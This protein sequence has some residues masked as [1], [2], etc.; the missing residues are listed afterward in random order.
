MEEFKRSEGYTRVKERNP[1][2]WKDRH[3]PCL[4]SW[5]Q[6]FADH[7]PEE[8]APS[9]SMIPLKVHFLL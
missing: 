2:P 1:M 7:V 8:A 4:Q 6:S 9:S 3:D 5:D